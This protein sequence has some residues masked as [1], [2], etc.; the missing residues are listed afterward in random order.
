[1]TLVYRVVV[2]NNDCKKVLKSTSQMSPALVPSLKSL[3]SP[4]G[5]LRE[6]EMSLLKNGE[7]KSVK[8]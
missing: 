4:W 1:M 3:T 5:I 2:V 7:L 6:Q 8:L